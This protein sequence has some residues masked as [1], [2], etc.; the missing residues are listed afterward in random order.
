[1]FSSQTINDTR[2]GAL[3]HTKAPRYR[4]FR[5]GSRKSD[6]FRN[7]F[8]TKLS[9]GD[10]HDA[11]F[12]G[13]RMIAKS[14]NPLEICGGVVRFDRVNMI[15]LRKIVGVRNERQGHKAMNLNIAKCGRVAKVNKHVSSFADICSEISSFVFANSVSAST[16]SRNSIKA[17]HSA[18]SADFVK[19]R[20]TVDGDGSP[21]LKH[22]ADFRAE[23]LANSN[24]AYDA[25]QDI[26]G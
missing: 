7:I 1:M 19:I 26:G 3:V 16:A 2:N 11:S 5:F 6:N 22:S 20:E 21:F 15:D 24:S 18:K 23:M 4:A 9:I 14:G 8:V 13:M 25:G 10:W 17:S 12:N